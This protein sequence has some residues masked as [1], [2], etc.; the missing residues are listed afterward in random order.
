VRKPS[1]RQHQSLCRQPGRQFDRPVHHRNDGKL[2]PQNT[3]TRRDLPFG[4]YRERI[5]PVVVDTYQPLPTA[6]RSAVLGSIAVYP[7]P[8]RPAILQRHS[9]TRSRMKRVL[10]ALCR[11]GYASATNATICNPMH[12]AADII[13]PPESTCSRMGYQG[14]LR[15]CGPTTPR[16]TQTTSSASPS[17]PVRA[18]PL[19]G[20]PLAGAPSLKH[21]FQCVL[22]APFELGTCLPYWPA[23]L[24]E[25]T[26]RD[27][28]HGWQGSCVRDCSGALTEV[29]AAR[30]RPATS[31][32][33]RCRSHLFLRLR[34]QCAGLHG[35]G[36]SASSGV[37]TN[38][39]TYA[40]AQSRAVASIVNESFPFHGNY[41]YN[42]ING[43]VSALR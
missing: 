40:T 16:Q 41:L 28:C 35:L 1:H 29:G 25:A 37:L 30:F 19:N 36:Y 18:E 10:L 23:M 14:F 34:D 17:R 15:V 5:E 33:N 13:E 6:R 27:G 7:S 4:D 43:T 12:W 39:G 31:L 26:L 32:G 24:P 38:L 9:R 11:T 22:N 21:L 2:Y 3:V 42:G 8:H 20:A